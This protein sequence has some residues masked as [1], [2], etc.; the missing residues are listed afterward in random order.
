MAAAACTSSWIPEDNLLLK[1][2]VEMTKMKT[3][4]TKKT[5]T[6]T[7]TKN[8]D[9]EDEAATADDAEPRRRARTMDSSPSIV[10]S[11]RKQSKSDMGF[12]FFLLTDLGLVLFNPGSGF[13]FSQTRIYKAKEIEMIHE[14]RKLGNIR[15]Q[16]Y[17]MRKRIRTEFFSSADLGFLAEPHLQNCSGNGDDFH[18][19]VTLN[20]DLPIG[21]CLLADCMPTHFGL[22]HTKQDILS[23]AFPQT[24]T[25]ITAAN[26]AGNVGDAS[27]SRGEDSLSHNQMKTIANKERLR[28]FSEDTSSFSVQDA[29][30][31]DETESGRQTNPHNDNP[32]C[33]QDNPIEF[34]KCLEVEKMETSQLQL[35]REHFDMDNSQ[36]EQ[37]T[38]DSPYNNVQDACTEF[39]GRQHFSSLNSD[40]SATFHMM[41]FSPPLTSMPRWKM[42]EELSAP[43]MPVNT[44]PEP[45]EKGQVAEDLSKSLDND[46]SKTKDSSV[47]GVIASGTMLIDKPNGYGLIDSTAMSDVEFADLPYSLLDFSNDGDILFTD[48]GL[49]EI[50]DKSSSGKGLLSASSKHVNEGN[51]PNI[52]PKIIISLDS[53]EVCQSISIQSDGVT[54]CA[55]NTEDPEI[56]CN[57]DIFLLI[58]PAP[59]FATSSTMPISTHPMDHVSFADERD[60]RQCLNLMKKGGNPPPSFMPS[61]TG[62]PYMFSETGQDHIIVDDNIKTELFD[63]SCTILAPRHKNMGEPPQCGSAHTTLSPALDVELEKDVQKVVDSPGG[64]RALPLHAEAGSV[65]VALPNSDVPE[66]DNDVASFSDVEAMILEMDLSLY[67]QDLYFS[68]RVSK[69]HPE[70]SKRSIMR[71]EQCALS[72]LQRAMA[73]Q[74]VILGQSTEE[75]DVDID[76]GK[77]GLANKNIQTTDGSFFLKNLGKSS[78][79]VNVKAIGS[80]QLLNLTLSCL[81]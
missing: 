66:S 77:D 58:H 33:L 21:N 63:T 34:E 12:F 74:E 56:P 55:L 5:K 10:R 2:S 3:Q 38:F 28:R 67:E 48:V 62:G 68:R 37:L 73:S 14:K 60:K 30:R 81:I 7:K 1:N 47:H 75:I 16:Y 51:V 9:A 31:S 22:Q 61:P 11:D 29:L 72:S 59:P 69:Y 46:D 24:I 32:H 44:N 50:M 20:V 64:F 17:A 54:C 41:D 23:H 76:L 13:V 43:A 71:L 52:G 26:P 79:L 78:I 49:K 45:E 42:M 18:E 19:H 35:G 25:E 6:N 4:K 80:G 65:E 15:E 27:H 39:G 57:D 70:D 36:I 53:G 8:Q 40:G